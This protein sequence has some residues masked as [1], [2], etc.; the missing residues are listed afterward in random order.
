ME[1]KTTEESLTEAVTENMK[2]RRMLTSA[3]SSI[4][5]KGIIS[6]VGELDTEVEKWW[7]DTKTAIRAK[8][9]ELKAQMLAKMTDEERDALL[10]G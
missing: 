2:L 10:N 6:D 1:S 3:L 8:R 5:E 7:K 9:K 4:E